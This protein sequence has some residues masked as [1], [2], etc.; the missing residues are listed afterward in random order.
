MT[1][2]KSLIRSLTTLVALS[3]DQAYDWLPLSN[4]APQEGDASLP[5]LQEARD[6]IDDIE[7]RGWELLNLGHLDLNAANPDTYKAMMA[8]L[9]SFVIAAGDIEAI[10]DLDLRKTVAITGTRNGTP[11]GRGVTRRVVE[12]LPED[13]T[14]IVPFSFGIP[15]TAIDTALNRNLP[16]IAVKA[17][18]P[19]TDYPSALKDYYEEI[20][21]RQDS[22]VVTPF[23]SGTM[24]SAMNFFFRN[25]LIAAADTLFVTESKQKGRGIVTARIAHEYGRKIYAAPGRLDCPSSKGCITLIE[26]GIADILTLR[27]IESL[28]NR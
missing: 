1:P 20:T 28:S 12:S 10:K 23:L 5:R 21:R 22:A 19:E 7:S 17:C 18:A 6:L 26:E 4:I 9:P 8:S 13:T 24:P 16:V 2:S 11:Y 3:L 15:E 14:L 25:R 27:V